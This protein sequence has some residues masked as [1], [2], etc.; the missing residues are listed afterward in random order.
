[1]KTNFSRR[2][3]IT[4]AA[5][6]LVGCSTTTQTQ[7]QAPASQ[8]KSGEDSAIKTREASCNCGQLRV[9]CKGPDPERIS[10]CHCNLCQK[11]S[12]SVFAVQARFPREQVTI[13]GKSTAWKLPLAKAKLTEYRNCASLGGG[14]TFHFCPVC[15]STVWYTADADAAR[16]GVKIGAFTDP[17]FPAPKISAFEEYQHPWAMN[18]AAL[19]MEH[20]K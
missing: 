18:V 7:A 19:P 17:T 10:L 9:T 3:A 15:G 14:G 5:L 13:E 20:V 16:I 4:V 11:Q 12:G 6:G 1:M 2:D 8:P